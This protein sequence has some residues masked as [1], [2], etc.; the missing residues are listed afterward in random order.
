MSRTKKITDHSFVPKQGSRVCGHIRQVA[1]YGH[2]IQASSEC[3][4][5]K[6]KHAE[7][8]EEKIFIPSS[9][10]YVSPAEFKELKAKA[11]ENN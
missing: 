9:G 5:P 4:A 3:C 10:E 8:A 2:V 11:R 7:N 1:I 6:W